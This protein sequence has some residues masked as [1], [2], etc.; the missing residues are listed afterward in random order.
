MQSRKQR[1]GALWS[2][3]LASLAM[4]GCGAS[5]AG[6]SSGGMALPPVTPTVLVGALPAGDQGRNDVVFLQ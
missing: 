1:T 6:D 5:E 3:A 2:L 4:A